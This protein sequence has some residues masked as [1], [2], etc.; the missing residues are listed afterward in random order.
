MIITGIGTGVGKTL[1][2][3]IFVQG[4]R[5][6]YW[7]PVQAGSLKSSDSHR[8]GFLVGDPEARIHPERFRLRHA[9]SPHAAARRDNIRI[10]AKELVVPGTSR[11]LIIE[12]AGGLFVPLNE[13]EV[14]VDF[15]E[16]LNA[17]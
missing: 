17:N 6:D 15:F 2:A 14:M 3:S 11:P 7:K 4:L 12:G 9:L 10:R 13:R 5:G 1:V 8:V 16:Q